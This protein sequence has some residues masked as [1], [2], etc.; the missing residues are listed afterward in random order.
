MDPYQSVASILLATCPVNSVEIRLQA[1]LDD[2]WAAFDL[3][4]SLED[5]REEIAQIEGLNTHYLYKNLAEIRRE[6]AGDNGQLWDSCLFSIKDGKFSI[7]V[8]YDH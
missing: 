2:G 4:C 8:K 6:M 1:E 3:R 5:G 7:K